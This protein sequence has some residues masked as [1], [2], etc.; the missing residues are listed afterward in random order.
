METVDRYPHITT[1]SSG[2]ACL[3]RLP[4]VRV[5]QIA[6]DHIAHGWTAEDILRQHD[7]LR[8]AEIHAALAYYYDNREQIDHEIE[9]EIKQVEQALKSSKSQPLASRLAILKLRSA[10]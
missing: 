3:E 7:Y 5:A 1:L 9:S 8:P 2:T 10:A 4:R 6:M